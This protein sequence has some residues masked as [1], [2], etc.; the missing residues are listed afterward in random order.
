MSTLLSSRVH[1]ETQNQRI[2]R[3]ERLTKMRAYPQLE[4]GVN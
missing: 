2:Y 4:A 3:T 1:A